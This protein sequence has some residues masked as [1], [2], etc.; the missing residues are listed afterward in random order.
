MTT[1]EKFVLM[2]TNN[3][4]EVFYYV[5]NGPV[6]TS[7]ALGK[8]HLIDVTTPD[9]TKARRFDTAPEAASVLLDAG[10][11]CGWEIVTTT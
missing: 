4:R 10:R 11:P 3:H 5:S 7:S 6:H 2:F 8:I 9:I 1:E